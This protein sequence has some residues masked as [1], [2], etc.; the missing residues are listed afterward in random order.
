MSWEKML[1][2]ESRDNN[3]VKNT[4]T[5]VDVVEITTVATDDSCSCC[6][7]NNNDCEIYMLMLLS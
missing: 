6:G 5:E 3:V 4:A 7:D 1:T 2:N